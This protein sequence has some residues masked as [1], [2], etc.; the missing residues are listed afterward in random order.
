MAR[1]RAFEG[2]GQGGG[3]EAL[4]KFAAEHLAPSYRKSVAE[5][6]L[7]VLLRAIR[8]ASAG[9]DDVRVQACPQ[10]IRIELRGAREARITFQVE[11]EAPYKI[12]SLSYEEL[13]DA[14]GGPAEPPLTWDHLEQRLLAAKRAGF[15]GA[16]IVV[17]DGKTIVDR[18]YGLADRERGTPNST[19]T[20]FG[21]GSVPIDFT[22]AGDE[23]P[24][25][26][27]S[28]A[29]AGAV[30]PAGFEPVCGRRDR[31]PEGGMS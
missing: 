7:F 11:P 30:L 14:G 13:A 26:R 10:E 31:S 24:G 5:A 21:I 4:R 6:E 17:R 27:T 28:T 18:G 23:V 20:I 29:N 8:L 12:T 3:D 25:G 2:L 15:S 9:A 1:V 22:K 16:V 19:D